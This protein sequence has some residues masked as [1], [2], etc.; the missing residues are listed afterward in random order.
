[1]FPSDMFYLTGVLFAVLGDLKRRVVAFEAS[2][3]EAGAAEVEEVE[4]VQRPIG[5]AAV[6][7][8]R[9]ATACTSEGSP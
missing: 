4:L 9:G 1:M 2:K 8:L 7:A 6:E 5:E 3:V